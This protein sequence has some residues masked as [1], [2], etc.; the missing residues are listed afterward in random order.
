MSGD[1]ARSSKALCLESVAAKG[2]IK[3]RSLPDTDWGHTAERTR[4]KTTHHELFGRKSKTIKLYLDD[5]GASAAKLPEGI[6]GRVN[7][8]DLCC[9]FIYFFWAQPVLWPG[10][11]HKSFSP[12]EGSRSQDAAFLTSKALLRFPRCPTTGR[13]T[14]QEALP[15]YRGFSITAISKHSCHSCFLSSNY[16]HR[17][18]RRMR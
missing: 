14:A 13:G 11:Y 7:A 8:L 17:K 5:M 6:P 9:G 1:A 12:A 2:W 16:T 15:H 18:H 4:R 10:S 3:W